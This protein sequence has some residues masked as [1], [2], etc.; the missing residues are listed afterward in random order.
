M[1]EKGFKSLKKQP[2]QQRSHQV[3]EAV[4]EAATRILSKVR[5]REATTNKIAETA[6]VSIGSLYDYF[7]NKNS[8]AIS[9]IDKRTENIIADFRK[10]LDGSGSSPEHLV[11]NSVDFISRDFFQKR[12][13][14]REI[15]FLAPEA[16]RMESLYRSR[17]E[18]TKA[19]QDHFVDKM[20]KDP[21]W[22]E[23]KSFLVIHSI[24]GFLESYV[25]IED[26]NFDPDLMKSELKRLMKSILEI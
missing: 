19:L 8:I 5:L 18:A 12:S 25:M 15:F 26:V 6:G 24:V 4:L 2:K 9:L 7:P 14:L 20:Q 11:Q 10:L 13:L 1:V 16:G 23:W 21:A 3:V 17:I 22:A